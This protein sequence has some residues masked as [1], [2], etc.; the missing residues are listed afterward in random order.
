[1]SVNTSVLLDKRYKSDDEPAQIPNEL[2]V[3][4]Y[5]NRLIFNLAVS[6]VAF[7]F[8]RRWTI[9]QHGGFIGTNFMKA[10]LPIGPGLFLI[11][12]QLQ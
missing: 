9:Q 12:P 5:R 6:G 8:I 2:P 3:F 7:Y 11:S 10:V 4:K 1:M